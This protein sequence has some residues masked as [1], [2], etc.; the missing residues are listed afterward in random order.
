MVCVASWARQ[1]G[2]LCVP[3]HCR[4]HAQLGSQK[5]AYKPKSIMCDCSEADRARWL[6][7]IHGIIINRAKKVS[8]RKCSSLLT[9]LAAH[10][11]HGHVAGQ[12]T[13]DGWISTSP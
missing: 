11:D 8:P 13:C 12:Q 1:G 7:A 3:L 5:V 10:R 6:V 9:L 4:Q 2:P